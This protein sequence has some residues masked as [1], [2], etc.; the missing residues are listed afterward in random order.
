MAVQMERNIVQPMNDFIKEME[1]LWKLHLDMG[2]DYTKK[3]QE[4][5]TTWK[6]AQ[7]EY[8]ISRTNTA[9]AADAVFKAAAGGAKKTYEK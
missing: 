6:K 2:Q 4:S 7:Q 9:E 1:G 8:D 5:Q 3:L